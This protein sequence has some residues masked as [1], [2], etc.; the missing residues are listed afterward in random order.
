M[1]S[2]IVKHAKGKRDK[3]DAGIRKRAGSWAYSPGKRATVGDQA[4]QAATHS[5][6]RLLP[7]LSEMGASS[8]I[9]KAKLYPAAESTTCVNLRH[10]GSWPDGQQAGRR[11]GRQAG[12]RA[13]RQ[14][15]G[16]AS[17]RTPQQPCR[18]GGIASTAVAKHALQLALTW[19]DNK[20]QESTKQ[21]CC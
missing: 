20:R 3:G 4:G 12:G 16:Q 15:G 1:G 8:S 14:A 9:P 17:R 18:L 10:A 13:D 2:C 19:H 11:A 5:E 21:G 6:A 7:S